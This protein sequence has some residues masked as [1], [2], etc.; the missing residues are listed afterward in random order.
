MKTTHRTNV[1]KA[2]RQYVMTRDFDAPRDVV[3]AAWTDA[4]RLARWWGPHGI[5]NPVCEVDPRPGGAY[6]IEMRSPEGQR[7]PLK[8]VFEEIVPGRR[9]VM[10]MD[11]SEHPAE[12]HRQL[13]SHRAGGSTA[14]SP[15]LVTTVIL[16]EDSGTTRA[17]VRQRFDDDAD[18]DAFLEMGSIEGWSQS[19]ERL[20][21]VLEEGRV[22]GGR[23]RGQKGSRPRVPKRG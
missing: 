21:A 20:D 13:A 15:R 22:R 17:T 1:E 23:P 6:R 18:R 19:F 16:D 3:Y 4:R 11:T 14:G 10:S 9:L 5:T 7:Y 2:A 12:W 8:G